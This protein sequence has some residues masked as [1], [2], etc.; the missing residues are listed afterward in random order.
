MLSDIPSAFSIV[1]LNSLLPWHLE[2]LLISFVSPYA[3]SVILLWLL[4]R[5]QFGLLF[6]T[7]SS[8]RRTWP[9]TIFFYKCPLN[10]LSNLFYI[11]PVCWWTHI[12]V[13]SSNLF[14]ESHIC[15]HT[16]YQPWS[17]ILSHPISPLFYSLTFSIYDSIIHL[18][19]HVKN[20]KSSYIPFSLSYPISDQ[21]QSPADFT[22]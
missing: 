14:P 18:I 1:T 13:S 6:N 9:T 4:H 20:L 17:I 11:L 5:R 2:Y 12:L 16:V 22:S 7:L 10:G 15:P 21:S 19:I 8:G 3:S